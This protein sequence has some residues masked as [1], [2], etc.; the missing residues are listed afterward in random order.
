MDLDESWRDRYLVSAAITNPGERAALYRGAERG[1]FA[2]VTRGAYL[3]AEEWRSLDVEGRHLARMRA[4]EL[5]HP[6]TV[7]SH[8]SAALVWGFPVVG[9]DLSIPF[10]VVEPTSG[11]RSMTGLRRSGIARPDAAMR[12]GG[13][14]VTSPSTTVLHIAAGFRPETSVPVI[15]A[16]LG[17][18]HPV[19]R[20]V[21][22]ERAA[23]VPTSSGSARCRW[24]LDFADPRSGSAGESLSRVSIHR[25]RLPAPELQTRFVDRFGSI[26]IVD[27]WWSEWELIGEFDGLGKYLREEF[28]KGKSPAEVVIAEKRREDRLRALGPRVAR[29]GWDDARDR[30]ALRSILAAGGLRAR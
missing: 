13:L 15:D 21:L 22:R 20:D 3:R 19:D 14:T 9:G 10:S 24:A 30:A 6:G 7:F 26:G 8:L 5:T 17:A 25:L 16:A 23:S 12:V 18:S 2:R 29:W 4:L 27:F 28:A 11:G 1:V